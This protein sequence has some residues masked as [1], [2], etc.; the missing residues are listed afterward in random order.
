MDEKTGISFWTGIIFIIVGSGTLRLFYLKSFREY[1]S[2]PT[3]P[4]K[5]I[6]YPLSREKGVIISG[7]ICIII[8]IAILLCQFIKINYG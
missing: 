7:I 5:L 2:R 4:R 6:K 3:I 1:I 8:G